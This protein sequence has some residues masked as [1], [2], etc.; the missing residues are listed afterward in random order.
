MLVASQ[1]AVPT[2]RQWGA[3]RGEGGLLWSTYKATCRRNGVFT[4]S[5]GPRDFNDELFL[6]ISK[7]V[8]AGWERA[9]VRRLPLVIDAFLRAVRQ[10]LTDFH[11]KASAN[12][13]ASGAHHGGLNILS[14]QLQAHLQSVNEI[15]VAGL[16]MAQE[17]QREANRGFIPV[18][19]Q[20]MMPAYEDCVQER[21]T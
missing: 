2:A 13:K 3:S 9:F 14:Q 20:E 11:S 10:H 6:P 17:I 16:K 8:A 21:G 4:G 12:A 19:Q 1:A 15:G 7:H 18:I 5:A